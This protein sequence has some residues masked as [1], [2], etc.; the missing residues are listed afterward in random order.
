M[1]SRFSHIMVE[2]MQIAIKYLNGS[3]TKGDGM[4]FIMRSS[5]DS[6]TWCSPLLSYLNPSLHSVQLWDSV[7][8][9]QFS[10]HFRQ[11]FFSV[12]KKVTR[13]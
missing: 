6:V 11:R 1:A 5:L 4:R 3:E 13:L 8:V 7:H 12:T 9:L 2:I 10:L